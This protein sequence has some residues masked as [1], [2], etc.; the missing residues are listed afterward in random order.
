MNLLV[1]QQGVPSDDHSGAAQLYVQAHSSWAGSLD[2]P[3]WLWCP[4]MFGKRE[5]FCLSEK[6]PFVRLTSFPVLISLLQ[7]EEQY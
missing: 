2:A 3:S 5:Q 7:G 4:E 1:L 6:L